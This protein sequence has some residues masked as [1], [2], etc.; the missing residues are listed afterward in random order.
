[1]KDPLT[2]EDKALW[3]LFSEGID[4][5]KKSKEEFVVLPLPSPLPPLKKQIPVVI[6]TKPEMKP[7]RVKYELSP[8]ESRH[9]KNIIIDARLDL[10]GYKLD[11]AEVALSRFMT[12]SQQVNRRWVLIISGKGLHSAEGR[13]T[14]KKF[15]QEWFHQN[16]HLVTGF[17]ESKPQDG[18]AGAFY[19]KVRRLRV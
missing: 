3:R 8:L 1:M 9:L 13:G 11:Q 16:T 7:R 2:P 6:Q 19:V 14:L 12:T 17:S 10:H 15:V 18:G 5:L 4:R